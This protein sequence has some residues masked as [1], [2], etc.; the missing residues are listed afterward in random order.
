MLIRCGRSPWG[1]VLRKNICCKHI[2]IPAEEEISRIAV[3]VDGTILFV[4]HRQPNCV[5]SNIV[6]AADGY[7]VHFVLWGH[8]CRDNTEC[9][10][11]SYGG[12][13]AQAF[14][15]MRVEGGLF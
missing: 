7:G 5:P 13:K 9:W 6:G 4:S 2:A 11:I 1:S 14:C 3:I 8:N 12:E 10:R 15:S